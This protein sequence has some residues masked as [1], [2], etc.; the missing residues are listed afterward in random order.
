VILLTAM[1][2]Q[3]IFSKRSQSMVAQA[4]TV[5]TATPYLRSCVSVSVA[6]YFAQRVS[7][8]VG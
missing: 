6:Q 1:A 4:K 8:S 5:M 7:A 3:D 2:S